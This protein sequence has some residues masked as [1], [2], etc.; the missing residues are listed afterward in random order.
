MKRTLEQLK[1]LSDENRLR[2]FNLISGRS[3]CACELLAILDIAGSTL[4]AHLKILRNAELIDSRKDGRWIEYFA[5]LDDEKVRLLHTVVT[6]QLPDD[7]ALLLSDLE[8]A[9]TLTREVCRLLPK[10]RD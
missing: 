8:R 5:R 2:I 3:M 9:R 1:A 4:S 10:E 6:K 7:D